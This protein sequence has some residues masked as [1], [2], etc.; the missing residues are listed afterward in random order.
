[1]LCA[2]LASLLGFSL[3]AAVGGYS[4]RCGVQHCRGFSGC[5]GSRVGSAV[6]VHRLS[7]PEARG[8]SPVQGSNL[9]PVLWQAD[10]QPLDYQGSPCP[11][12]LKDKYQTHN[13]WRWHY[14][15]SP[16]SAPTRPPAPDLMLQATLNSITLP[17]KG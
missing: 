2:G 12:F 11:H 8:T 3:V 6:A 5:A 15:T 1:M 9:C 14:P 17:Q 7:C 16:T 10:S 4:P 13:R